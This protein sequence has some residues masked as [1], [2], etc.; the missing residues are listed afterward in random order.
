LKIGYTI[1]PPLLCLSIVLCTGDCGQA[2][3]RQGQPL[4]LNEAVDL[5]LGNYPSIRA[6]LAQAAAAREG[7][8]LAR[9]S[10]LPRTD[11]LWQ[12]NRATRNN[13]FGLVLPQPVIPAVS[14]PVLAD[15]SYQGTW[16]SAGGV[17]LSWEPF[18]FGLRRAQVQ[19]AR[20]QTEQANAKVEVTRLDVGTNASDAF[21]TLLATEQAVRAARANVDRMETVAKSVHVLVDN[22]LRP[23][24]D[25]SRA[26]AELA[27]ARIQLVQAEQVSEVSRVALGEALGQAELNVVADAGPLL[28]LPPELSLPVVRFESHPQARE[29]AAAVEVVRAKEHA[30]DRTY[31]PRFYFQTSVYGRGSGALTDGGFK[32][33]LNGL[34]PSVGNWATGMSVS[35]PL[36]DI[37]SIRSRRRIEASNESAERARYDQTILTLRA[38]DAR[39][40]T[41]VET[42]LR[43]AENTPIE[44]KAAREAEVRARARYEAQLGNIAEVADAERLLT[45]AEIDDSVARLGVWR[46]RLAAA[47]VRG[48]LKPFLQEVA[49]APVR[50]K[51]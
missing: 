12:E 44:L 10:Y 19:T 9:T 14:G 49:S 5:A 22:Q 11:V 25:A 4:K 21:L 15:Q 8:G 20:A 13:F 45:Q 33:G 32:G 50:K 35:F 47:R 17:L 39:A 40:R 34:F 29:Q 43:I 6:S 7:I 38:Q 37:F 23:G 3:Q 51:E 27:A 26:D 41:L 1:L 31:F 18:D 36:L 24:A 30:L 2:Q 42:A 46:A 48:D 16:G 28:D